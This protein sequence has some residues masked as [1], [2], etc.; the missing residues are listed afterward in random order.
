MGGGIVIFTY[1]TPPPR[2]AEN[3]KRTL[4]VGMSHF[5]NLSFSLRD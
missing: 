4:A 5:V 2:V 3:E 1:P